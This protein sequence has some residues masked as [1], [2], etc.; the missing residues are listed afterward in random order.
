[1]PNPQARLNFFAI[2]GRCPRRFGER[3][4]SLPISH[5]LS[6]HGFGPSRPALDFT[7]IFDYVLQAL[8]LDDPSCT[9]RAGHSAR[10]G[11]QNPD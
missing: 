3:S 10:A 4:R 9:N 11:S 2:A 7:P 1:M 8:R 5:A 6:A